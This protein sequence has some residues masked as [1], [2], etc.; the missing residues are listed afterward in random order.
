MWKIKFPH[1]QSFLIELLPP[2]LLRSCLF[3]PRICL[4]DSRPHLAPYPYPVLIQTLSLLIYIDIIISARFLLTILTTRSSPWV[5]FLAKFTSCTQGC[6]FW[7]D[8]VIRTFFTRVHIIILVASSWTWLWR[9]RKS[10]SSNS[11]E[12]PY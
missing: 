6:S 10:L 9:I 3:V 5:S 12:L 11:F 2:R 8:R 1:N 7:T 4:L